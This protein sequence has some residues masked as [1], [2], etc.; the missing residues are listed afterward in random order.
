MPTI[1]VSTVRV[2]ALVAFSGLTLGSCGGSDFTDIYATK[3]AEA[4]AKAS[5]RFG[6]GRLAGVPW[7]VP[8]KILTTL[9]AED[10]V[11]ELPSGET[12]RGRRV[13]AAEP[14]QHAE[15][16]LTGVVDRG[17]ATSVD[18][19]VEDFAAAFP[20]G[21]R[22]PTFLNDFAAALLERG[23]PRDL[24]LGGEYAARA[25]NAAE[26]DDADGDLAQAARFNWAL[27]LERLAL[28]GQA[29]K[30][31]Q[32]VLVR[33][34]DPAWRAE[35]ETH[36]AELAEWPVV[37]WPA[38]RER[39]RQAAAKG[40]TAT[41]AA[42]LPEFRTA[43]R[44][45]AEDE[46]LKVWADNVERDPIQAKEALAIAR[47]IGEVLKPTDALL[48]DIVAGIDEAA[49]DV[50][51]TAELAVA[52]RG[53][54]GGL[55]AYKDFAYEKA[56]PLLVEA[57]TELTN[58]SSPLLF[59]A[60]FF[61]L[62]SS[63]QLGLGERLDLYDDLVERLPPKYVAV[64]GQARYSR[65]A[66]QV[67]AGYPEAGLEDLSSAVVALDEL[68]ERDLE[69]SYR[70]MFGDA[71]A[72][73]YRLEEAA[74][75]DLEWL[76]SADQ[77]VVPY[78]R[79]FVSTAAGSR[80]A[81][82]SAFEVGLAAA[83]E[84]AAIGGELRRESLSAETQTELFKALGRLA[85]FEEAE[86]AKGEARA[87]IERIGDPFDRR[88]SEADLLRAEA[89]LPPRLWGRSRLELLEEALSGFAGTTAEGGNSQRV[90]QR[91]AIL[92]ELAQQNLV[93]GRFSAARES[94]EQAFS[95]LERRAAFA[96]ETRLDFAAEV[97]PTVD[98]RVLASLS[99]VDSADSD[100]DLFGWV[101]KGHHLSAPGIWSQPQTAEQVRAA[102]PVGTSLIEL[103]QLADRVLVLV[104]RPTGLEMRELEVPELDDLVGCLDP[105]PATCATSWDESAER[106]AEAA[107]EPWLCG[108]PAGERLVLVTGSLA[109][110]PFA[111]LPIQC[112]DE[113]RVRVLDR[114]VTSL[115][116]SAT[117]WVEAQARAAELAAAGPASRVL[118]VGL[119]TA[120]G[121]ETKLERAEA[122]AAAVA[123]LYG[124]GLALLGSGATQ[125]AIQE[126]AQQADVLH[127]ATHGAID[128]DDPNGSY[129]ALAETR[130][131]VKDLAGP[132]GR[133]PRT[134]LA[135]L[136]ACETGG[137]IDGK[138]GLVGVSRA[139]LEIGVPTVVA[140]L[141][142][143]DDEYAR[144]L[145][146]MFHRFYQSTGN[147]ALALAL[148][149][150]E[151][152]ALT[153]AEAERAKQGQS[154]GHVKNKTGPPEWARWVVVGE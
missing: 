32:A 39:L 22:D 153:R 29:T 81:P 133:L 25:R 125:E 86:R 51:K 107:V 88:R 58:V 45:M 89:S 57:A 117:S 30:A 146:V 17:R 34:T 76:A 4:L 14:I 138:E 102:L 73:A 63:D 55:A 100:D 44:L 106:F 35:A 11:A 64:K 110:V 147:A 5:H 21:Q 97:R 20:A 50:K 109:R 7:S 62:A 75:E 47:T 134:R 40:D 140:T 142:K 24:I 93:L 2:V 49:G 119:E 46:E 33:E 99:A 90:L 120:H 95:F 82:A 145:M 154:L 87:A 113:S 15:W 56:Q 85:R 28:H 16:G 91:T 77:A 94:A 69:H 48:G 74:R 66:I 65:G 68:G 151:A 121:F 79:Y 111:A 96:N 128:K 8:R 130:L 137:E 150:R 72:Q 42:I 132:T 71:L 60:E 27:A 115:A 101:E 103:S 148:A 144:D 105:R 123:G 67:W 36:A 37:R 1:L 80:A 136:S 78:Y 26:Q 141:S 31:W 3:R 38:A 104:S 98:L 131:A 139:F 12:T 152:P 9:P 124:Q 53:F 52:F 41:V 116:P 118:A 114:H 149:Q 23:R 108:L 70:S 92:R 61:E 19:V 6:P 129:L 112:P 54:F 59:R 84:S 10:R 126:R 18:E 122:E 135:V 13:S 143:V 83:R 43:A 127:F